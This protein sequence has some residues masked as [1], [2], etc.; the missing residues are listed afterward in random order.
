MHKKLLTAVAVLAIP[1]LALSLAFSQSVLAENCAMAENYNDTTVHFAPNVAVAE[2]T[3][4]NNTVELRSVESDASQAETELTTEARLNALLNMNYCYGDAF[5]DSERLATAISISLKDYAS[6]LPA[7]GICV[8]QELISGFAEDFYG[9]KI[10]FS[11]FNLTEMPDGYFASD[12]FEYGT[13]FHELTGLTETDNGFEVTS[14]VTFYY[15]G[16]D[17]E[18]YTALSTFENAPESPF[19]FVLTSCTL[20]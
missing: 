13:Q 16:N 15:G 14:T 17:I 5:D 1:V 7:Y 6:D 20:S 18:Q 2:E 11:D 12:C 19:L 3:L 10:D 9:K 4:Y 8:S